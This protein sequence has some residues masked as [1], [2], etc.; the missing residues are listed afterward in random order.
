MAN[1]ATKPIEKD[2]VKV[3]SISDLQSYAEGAVVQ[4]PEFADGMPFVAK[5]RRPSMLALAKSGRIPN[6]L[7]S[8]A[9][10]LFVKGSTGLDVDDPDMMGNF[11]DTCR[12]I[13]EAALVEPTMAD[14]ESAGLELS[15]NQIMAIFSYTQTGVRALESFR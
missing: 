10:E 2:T 14:I 13:C 6:A 3:T 4:L 12:V 11:Y 15:D 7:L 8:T 5:L 9:N 1:K